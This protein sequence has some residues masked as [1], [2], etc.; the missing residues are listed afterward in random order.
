MLRNA[1][2]SERLV[3]AARGVCGGTKYQNLRVVSCFRKMC[4]R[5]CGDIIFRL[6]LRVGRFR[7]PIGG[8]WLVGR[9]CM[10]PTGVRTM[11]LYPVHLP[12][13][14]GLI[15]MLTDDEDDGDVLRQALRAQGNHI[16]SN[17]EQQSF[18]ETKR[19][20]IAMVFGYATRRTTT[21][22]QQHTRKCDHESSGSSKNPP[23]VNMIRK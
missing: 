23:M 9:S 3:P 18:I 1:A 14:C 13:V 10:C 2:K 17:V 20:N 7:D 21:L 15:E 4:V 8:G 11:K 16:R 19:S 5:C 6:G 22:Q 12:S